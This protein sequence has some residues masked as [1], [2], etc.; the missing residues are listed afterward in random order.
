M[1]SEKACE[2]A[3]TIPYQRLG[4]QDHVIMLL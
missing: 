2:V 1:Q 4:K 3:F